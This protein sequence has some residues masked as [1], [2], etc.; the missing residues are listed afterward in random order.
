ML[1]LGSNF[2]SHDPPHAHFGIGHL[3]GEIDLEIQWPGGERT[4]HRVDS[5]VARHRIEMPVLAGKSLPQSE[6]QI[7][8]T[9]SEIAEV[10]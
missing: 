8:S 10:W 5:R 2:A 1:R 4:R 6:D 3:Y 9:Q 7:P